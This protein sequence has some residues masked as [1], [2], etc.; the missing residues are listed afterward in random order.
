MTLP[1]PV[2]AVA[3]ERPESAISTRLPLLFAIKP[4]HE[5]SYGSP[6][7]P[8]YGQ[9]LVPHPKGSMRPHFLRPMPS[10]NFSCTSS[11]VKR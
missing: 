1:M 8:S 3:T 4:A 7:A 9:P 6:R 10:R 2:Y 11:Q 5:P